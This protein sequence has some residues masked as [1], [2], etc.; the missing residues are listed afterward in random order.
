MR[1]SEKH[2]PGKVSF[3]T[4]LQFYCSYFKLKHC[5]KLRVSK[6]VKEINFKG[7]WGEL[8]ENNVSI[9]NHSQNIGD[10]L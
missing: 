6:I 7:I 3:F 9:D 2:L 10:Q 1:R 4:Y 8:E 5:E